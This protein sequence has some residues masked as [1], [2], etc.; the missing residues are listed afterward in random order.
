[1]KADNA[2]I[3]DMPLPVEDSNLFLA[4]M[5]Y[6]EINTTGL[7]FSLQLSADSLSVSTY[8]RA[9]RGTL[10]ATQIQH[11]EGYHLT[12]LPIFPRMHL[13]QQVAAAQ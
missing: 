4:Y 11:Q 3:H 5:Q 10:R 1:M 13:Q 9:P 2:E 8:Q 7:L 6:T 12:R